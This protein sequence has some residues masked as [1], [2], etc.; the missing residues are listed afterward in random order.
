MLRRA[1]LREHHHEFDVI[2]LPGR[3]KE[4]PGH[5]P[6]SGAPPRLQTVA[7]MGEHVPARPVRGRK[8]FEQLFVWVHSSSPSFDQTP[9]PQWNL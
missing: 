3:T 2:E 9:I 5:M 6:G 1:R 7:T 4:T 8:D